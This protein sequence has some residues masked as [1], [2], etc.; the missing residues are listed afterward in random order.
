M[1]DF[2]PT[3]TIYFFRATGVT[4]QNQ[5]FF[6]SEGAKLA[7]YR[8]HGVKS[9][10]ELSYQRENR[11]YVQVREK[12]SVMRA[13]DM[14]AF[15]NDPGDRWIFCRVL[16]A[17]FL[18]PNT[19][20]IRFETDAL[21]TFVDVCDFAESWV[22]REMVENDWNG[23]LPSFNNLIPEGLETGYPSKKLLSNTFDEI[24]EAG[25][26]I[27][28]L[29]AYD[30]LA[31]PNY[32]IKKEGAYPYGLNKIVLDNAG[33]LA[34]ILQIYEQKGRLDGISG[35]WVVPKVFKEY[36]ASTL[37]IRV[38]NQTTIAG[39][40]PKNAKCFSGEFC[41]IELSNRQ[42][43][44]VFLK[45]EYFFK[46]NSSA[47]LDMY[48]GFFAGNGGIILYPNTYGDDTV[49]AQDYGVFLPMDVQ[50]SY[51]GNAFANW[52][53]QYKAPILLEG[54]RQLGAGAVGLA[55]IAGGYLTG[56]LPMMGV[57]AQHVG[58]TLYD[59]ASSMANLSAK[60]QDPAAIG[61]QSNGAAFQVGTGMYGFSVYYVTPN[62]ETIKSIDDF[63]TV[64]GYRT[65]RAKR[66]NVNT[67]P[68]WNYVKCSQACVK[69]PFTSRDQA[70]I[71]ATLNAG[72]TFWH[73]QNGAV[74]GDYS[75]DNR[76]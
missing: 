41:N 13:Y 6:T 55:E 19:T 53:G 56:N 63:F 48:G 26:S 8:G 35:I 10:S 5:P 2:T 74:I 11:G 49:N 54:V 28:I 59:A 4:P 73:V 7:W 61:G 12:A 51:I 18:N 17:E 31:E 14:M 71:Q 3:T 15:Q 67:R 22:E 30:S 24:M 64:Y 57:G 52:V 37:H 75:M 36:S 40:K 29:S 38:T 27:V 60:A 69:G 72:V 50:T 21:Q 34:A 62:E 1:A 70:D 33:D 68:F 47:V 23:I 45:P 46:Q 32:S 43:T 42:G 65:C 39:Y 76:G 44:S 20:R 9:F 16:E 25:T 58:A 66:P